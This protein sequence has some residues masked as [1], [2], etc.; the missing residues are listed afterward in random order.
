M[1]ISIPP[2]G[3]VGGGGAGG[4]RHQGVEQQEVPRIH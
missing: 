1:T 4:A 3:A 2:V